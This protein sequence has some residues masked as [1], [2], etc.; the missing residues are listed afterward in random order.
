MKRIPMKKLIDF[1]ISFLMKRGVSEEKARY[2]SNIIVE[3]E[4][5]RQSTHGIV[6]FMAMHKTIGNKIDPEKDPRLIRDFGAIGLLDGEYCF[7]N[8]AMR[9][10]KHLALQKT[11]KYGIGFVAVRNTTW[12]GAL[13]IYLLSIAQEGLLAQIWA[14]TSNCQDCAPFGGI[15]ARLSTNPIAIAIPTASD[16]IIADFS[17]TTMSWGAANRMIQNEKI[18]KTPQFLDNKG[19]PSTDPNVIKNGGTVMLSGGDLDG[20][21]FYALSLF[22]ESLTAM[23]GASANNPDSQ[24]HQS[25]S[26]MIIDPSVFAGLEYYIK[27]IKRFI[28]H[29]KS[30]H[31]RSGFDKVRLPGERGFKA[32]KDCKKNGIPL[33]NN[34]ID[35]LKQIAEQNGI[36]LII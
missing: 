10:A 27:E 33:D 11:N 19:I 18:A 30:A 34:K 17:T 24:S 9:S 36:E 5:F 32:L 16:P 14:Q 21:K 4:A 2:I 31:P 7:G 1:G 6:Q 35:M 8:I 22:I 15:E 13:G 29:I 3:T 23:S 25:F 28:K 26:L 20:Y 12:I